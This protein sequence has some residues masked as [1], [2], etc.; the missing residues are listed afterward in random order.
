MFESDASADVEALIKTDAEFRQLY[1]HHQRLNS[2]VMNA[3]LGVL[4]I[5]DVRL[6][7]LKKEKLAAKDQLTRMLARTRH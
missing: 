1:R 5:D 4:P 6:T 7:K 2:K 3:E